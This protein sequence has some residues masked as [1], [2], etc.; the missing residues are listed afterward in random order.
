VN[1]TVVGNSGS[2]IALENTY[3]SQES[4]CEENTLKNNTV[5]DNENDGI[6]IYGCKDINL[7]GNTTNWNRS[8]IYLESFS[9]SKVEG[10]NANGNGE[11][12]IYLW[13]TSRNTLASNT[14][15]YN[16]RGGIY[17]VESD[18]LTLTGNISNWNGR[19][20]ISL[21]MVE[22]CVLTANEINSNG[23]SGMHL[24]LCYGNTIEDNTANMNGQIFGG[25]GYVDHYGGDP[26]TNSWAKNKCKENYSGGSAHAGLGSDVFG[27]LC[28]PQY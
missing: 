7:I 2:G 13:H 16:A 28:K 4:A 18:N 9:D 19:S 26:W 25:Y 24:S 11:L 27:E 5:L 1:N 14:T 8:G 22:N 17:L 23:G 3:Y 20:G 10:N 21:E 12:G 15:I 6:N